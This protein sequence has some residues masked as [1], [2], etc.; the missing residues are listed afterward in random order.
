MSEIN[1][2]LLSGCLVCE[3]EVRE[4]PV[5]IPVCFMRVCADG[6]WPMGGARYGRSD[7]TDVIVLGPKVRRI[8]PFLYQ[9]RGVVIE[10]S[11]ESACWEEGEGPEHEAV[12]V[13]A[14]RVD[15]MGRGPRGVRALARE[16]V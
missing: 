7:C 9:G 4:L 6:Q 8:A 3:P 2:V 16:L 15:F 12:C 1:R 5:G 11:L 10:G 14:D 13:L